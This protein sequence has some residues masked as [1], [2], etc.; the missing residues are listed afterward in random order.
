MYEPLSRR[1]SAQVYS[2]P[3]PNADDHPETSGDGPV[4]TLPGMMAGG[5]R[6]EYPKM[7]NRAANPSPAVATTNRAVTPSPVVASRQG[8]RTLRRLF[9]SSIGLKLI[10]AA[11]GVILS[12]FVLGHML[13]NLQIFQGKEAIDAYARFLRVE[14]ALLWTV[15]LG[16]LA[17]VALHIWAYLALTRQNQ[18]AQPGTG[19][20]VRHYKE[21]SYAS[22][23]MRLTGPLL[24]AFIIYHILH[25][26]T[27]TVHS[28]F[29]EGAV[30]QNLIGAFQSVPV[31]VIYLLSMAMLA[32]HLW[33]G[34]WSVFQTLGFSQPRYLS[35]GRRV[36][37]VF[38]IVV[39]LGF[40]AVPLAIL[41]GLIK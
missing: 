30:Y 15:R 7:T 11:T 10:T 19:Y 22:R 24:L 29:H 20:R 40:S 2:A 34:V 12:L 23:S 28:S 31:A 37:T 9:R 38:T 16:L 5:I 14:P 21:S 1:Y 33:H 36:A 25:M 27:G 3:T 39:V 13:G 4:P 8:S 41:A 26:T 18:K 6:I 17:A 32:L 35:L